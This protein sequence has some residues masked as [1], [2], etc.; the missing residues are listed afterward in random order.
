MSSNRQNDHGSG[1]NDRSDTRSDPALPGQV[2]HCG[3]GICQGSNQA[4]HGNPNTIPGVSIQ[5]FHGGNIVINNYFCGSN[6]TPSQ[7]D[8]APR[9]PSDFQPS[10]QSALENNES[11][12][13]ST[14]PSHQANQEPGDDR[15][16]P[17]DET[18]ATDEQGTGPVI[19]PAQPHREPEPN[20]S[21]RTSPPAGPAVVKE[22]QENLIRLAQDLWQSRQER[23][24][25]SSPRRDRPANDNRRERSPIG[26][27]RTIG[28]AS[29]S[30]SSRPAADNVADENSMAQRPGN[31]RDTVQDDEDTGRAHLEIDILTEGLSEGQCPNCLLTDAGCDGQ[32]CT[33]ACRACGGEH[34]VWK[35]SS[36]A[37]M[38]Q[39]C[40]VPRHLKK[41][42]TSSAGFAGSGRDARLSILETSRGLWNARNTAPRAESG[43]L[44][45]TPGRSA[46]AH[47]A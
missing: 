20:R 38:C 2:R 47:A 5:H 24:R 21:R 29:M 18:T 30:N 7:S 42:A 34:P 6:Q 10:P 46:T 12:E 45:S 14:N 8:P 44:Q 9:Q 35:C 11:I 16:R 15:S 25:S 17:E 22:E 13:T 43:A 19:Q 39:C 36:L 33:S 1:S 4:S 23:G 31:A 32:R 26:I 27:Q 37:D 40:A 41:D 28:P 3:N